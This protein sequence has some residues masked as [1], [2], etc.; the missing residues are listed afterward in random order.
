MQNR[1]TDLEIIDILSSLLRPVSISELTRIIKHQYGSSHYPNINRKLHE[2]KRH[3]IVYLLR[4]GGSLAT[5]LNF[6]NYETMN[7]LAAMEAHKE[8][9]ILKDSPIISDIILTIQIASKNFHFIHSGIIANPIENL[10]L[11]RIELLIILKPKKV[12]Q[13]WRKEFDEGLEDEKKRLQELVIRLSKK[14]VIRIDYLLL[15]RK[16]FLQL[17]QSDEKNEVKEM[18]Y[19]K[20]VFLEPNAFWTELKE[21]FEKG[22]RYSELPTEGSYETNPIDITENDMV[23]NLA[24][25]GYMEFGSSVTRGNSYS[26][27]YIITSILMNDDTRR[28]E[29]IPILIEK[30]KG[31]IIVELLGF[32]CRKYNVLDKLLKTLDTSNWKDTSEYKQKFRLY[33]VNGSV[34]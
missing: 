24:R 33:Y 29:S 30:N 12:D 25:F 7:L 3:N 14:N 23:F 19:R 18:M 13:S 26:I 20:L 16:D 6:E 32:L 5:T 11:N 22:Y 21:T 4:I 10:N 1:S 31:G 8:K 34:E 15:Q 17:I 27:E 28:I 2:M 9:E